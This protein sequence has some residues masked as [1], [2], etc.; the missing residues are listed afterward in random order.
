[1]IDKL[2]SLFRR[3]Q[4]MVV[5]DT[6]IPLVMSSKEL[7]PAYDDFFTS[8]AGLYL[9]QHIHNLIESNHTD[10]ENNPER[11]RDCAQRSKTAREI[12]THIKGVRAEYK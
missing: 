1:M 12:L 5:P 4:E 2:T 9:L 7:K 10:A 8:N 11:A 3:K 6:A